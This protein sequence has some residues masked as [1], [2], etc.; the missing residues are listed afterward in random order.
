MLIVSFHSIEDKIIKY[1]FLAIFQKINLNLQ[2][3]FL[4]GTN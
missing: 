4:I 2:D 3:I 1:F